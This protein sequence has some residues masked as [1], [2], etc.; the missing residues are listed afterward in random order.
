MSSWNHRKTNAHCQ[1][2]PIIYY[3]RI[4]VLNSELDFAV[5]TFSFLNVVLNYFYKRYFFSL[6]SQAVRSHNMTKAIKTAS[7]YTCTPHTT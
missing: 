1:P 3:H 4:N 6:F 2:M 5:K 7:V